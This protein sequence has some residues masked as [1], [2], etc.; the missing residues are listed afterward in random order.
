MEPL[1]KSKTLIDL[2]WCNVLLTVGIPCSGK[3]CFVSDYIKFLA[4]NHKTDDKVYIKGITFDDIE[5][6]IRQIEYDEVTEQLILKIWVEN[7]RRNV[8]TTT[9][10]KS[11]VLKQAKKRQKELLSS[12]KIEIW[13]RARHISLLLFDRIVQQKNEL[14]LSTLFII[15]EDN[16]LLKSMRKPI[17]R[18]CG[19]NGLSYCELHFSVSLEE[20]LSRNRKRDNPLEVSEETIKK[21]F[22]SIEE[23]NYP[24]HCVIYSQKNDKTNDAEIREINSA[25][26]RT[27]LQEVPVVSE[28]DEEERIESQ[29]VNAESILHQADLALR[30]LIRVIITEKLPSTTNFEANEPCL[31]SLTTVQIWV[32]MIESSKKKNLGKGLSTLKKFFT[33]LLDKTVRNSIENYDEIT[34]EPLFKQFKEVLDT[35][36]ALGLKK[37]E[38]PEELYKALKVNLRT[39]LNRVFDDGS[40]D[41]AE[42]ARIFSIDF[43]RIILEFLAC[44]VPSDSA[45]K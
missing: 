3:S 5:L 14:S 9:H 13:K 33:D 34:I 16:F 41:K 23:T 22:E 28:I 42:L 11:E 32:K 10:L 38:K 44:L 24:L 35:L 4:E 27:W 6:L 15:L 1:Q 18:A 29:K 8:Y 45:G 19:N 43:L 21:A 26:F 17:Y 39:A 20:A 31:K 25:I 40:K 36:V 2:Q 37:T 30:D 7:L 12:E